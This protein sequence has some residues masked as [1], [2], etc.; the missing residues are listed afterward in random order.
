MREAQAF[1]LAG[2]ILGRPPNDP[3]NTTQ[4]Q[5][6]R[7]RSP[8]STGNRIPSHSGAPPRPSR[9]THTS[10]FFPFTLYFP[11]L[12]FFADSNYGNR[13]LISKH[14]IQQTS[15]R[16]DYLHQIF[17]TQLCPSNLRDGIMSTTSFPTFSKHFSQ[18][19]TNFSTT[20]GFFQ[21]VPH[22]MTGFGKCFDHSWL[23]L[24]RFGHLD[25]TPHHLQNLY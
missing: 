4:A 12:F 10:F 2:E 18:R 13:R 22:A 21:H 15:L 7:G 19:Y 23:H 5:T 20:Y 11:R 9:H 24:G 8:S 6:P 17:E 16:R 1:H 3:S 14:H 25:P